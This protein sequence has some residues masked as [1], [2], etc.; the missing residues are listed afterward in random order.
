MFLLFSGPLL[1]GAVGRW[2][3]SGRWGKKCFHLSGRFYLWGQLCQGQWHMSLWQPPLLYV[4]CVL[5]QRSCPLGA[6][7]ARSLRIMACRWPIPSDVSSFYPSLPY[8][9]P[10]GQGQYPILLIDYFKKLLFTLQHLGKTCF[11]NATYT[12]GSLNFTLPS[13]KN[14]P[15]QYKTTVN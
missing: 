4:A 2:G 1:W 6:C 8:S 14:K 11:T 12:F 13:Q 15:T 3:V 9:H 10:P 7:T 5:I